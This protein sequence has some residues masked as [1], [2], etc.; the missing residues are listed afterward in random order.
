MSI[1]KYIKLTVERY[2]ESRE[3][4]VLLGAN[5]FWNLLT[6]GYFNSGKNSPVLKYTELGWV[7]SG[8]IPVPW[9]RFILSQTPPSRIQ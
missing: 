1:R 9:S 3:I 4:D 2:D 8:N 7:I 5:N 6:D